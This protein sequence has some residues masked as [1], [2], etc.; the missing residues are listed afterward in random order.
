MSVGQTEMITTW[1]PHCDRKDVNEQ[2]NWFPFPGDCSSN[3]VSNKLKH[4]RN[5]HARN[6]QQHYACMYSQIQAANQLLLILWFGISP[7]SSSACKR[8]SHSSSQR[9]TILRTMSFFSICAKHNTLMWICHWLLSRLSE[10]LQLTSLMIGLNIIRPSVILHTVRL[11][12]ELVIF[13]IPP[14][15][16]LEG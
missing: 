7:C 1:K 15:C 8:S 4:A 10:I 16:L 2:L 14:S 12:N 13:G 9:A 6:Q 11:G 5:K 3:D